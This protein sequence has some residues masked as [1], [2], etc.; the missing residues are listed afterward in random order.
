MA[1]RALTV[2]LA[3][4]AAV[5]LVATPAQ[6]T[7]GPPV[8]VT[9]EVWYG[10]VKLS[11]LYGSLSFDDGKTKFSYTLDVCRVSSYTP[12]NVWY[13]VNGG[14]RVPISGGGGAVTIPQCVYTAYRIS[15][16][17]SPGVVITKVTLYLDGV[18]FDNSNVAHFKERSAN[19]FN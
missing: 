17:P 13:S 18:Y 2:V 1:R 15:G 7:Y 11:G 16:E 12:P 6:A 19:F 14:G 10:S 8:P 5:L 3:M 4:L 9:M